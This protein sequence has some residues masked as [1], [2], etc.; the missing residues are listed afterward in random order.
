[1]IV[2]IS[3][4]LGA[5][6]LSVGE[7]IAKTLGAQLLD[8]RT[9]VGILTERLGLAESYVAESVERPRGFG[10]AL[11]DVVYATAMLGRQRPYRPSDEQLLE[12]ARGLVSEAAAEG[13]VVVIGHGGP[14]L[15][16]PF[17]RPQKLMMLLYA[18]VGWRIAQVAQRFSIDADEARRRVER[19]DDARAKYLQQ[20]FGVHPYEARDYDLV[21]NTES[22]GLDNAIAIACSVA[23]EAARPGKAGAESL[24]S[25]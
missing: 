9:I 11:I 10:G 21:M 25:D 8:E 2:S 23:K 1:M 19:V 15:L 17:P 6:G 24:R 18:G 14:V 20:N 7:A 22:I 3:R 12:A 16:R 5:G 4:E 13:D